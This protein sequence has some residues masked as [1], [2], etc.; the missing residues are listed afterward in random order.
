MVGNGSSNTGSA[1]TEPGNKTAGRPSA[2]VYR[3]R[4]IVAGVLV[5]LV[6]IGLIAGITAIANAVRGDGA[7]ASNGGTEATIPGPDTQGGGTDAPQAGAAAD[8]SAKPGGTPAPGA[9]PGATASASP[10]AAPECPA[11]AVQVAATTDA[12][13]YSAGTSPMLTMTVTNTG[14]EPCEVNVG[15]SQM[16]FT[17][18]SGS[19]RIFSSVDCM[20]ASQDLMM[21]IEP[22]SVETAK[23]SWERQRS[24]PGCAEVSSNPN[25]GTY[26][27]TTRLGGITSESTVFELE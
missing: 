14:E 18:T 9:T 20:Q 6:V 21:V 2:A 16:E 22:K 27:F 3:R 4:R 24:A 11:G 1:N 10:G 23:F 5:L 25:P 12:L 8:P 19:D 13:S 26:M 7:A 17:V 15:T